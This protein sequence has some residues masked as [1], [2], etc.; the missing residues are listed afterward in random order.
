MYSVSDRRDLSK[1]VFYSILIV[2]ALGASFAVGLYSGAKRTGLFVLA[3]SARTTI[4]SA[5]TTLIGQATTIAGTRP[6]GF[7]Q[8]S[9]S[10]RGGVTINDALGNQGDLILLSGF[11]GDTSELRLIRRSGSVV[12]RWPVSYY[13]LFK[14][15]GQFDDNAVPATDWN[16]DTHGALALPDGSVV[17]NFEYGGLVKLDRCGR[18]LWTVRRRTHHSVEAAEGGG[19]WVPARRLVREGPSPYRPFPTPFQEDTILKVTDDGTIAFEKSVP[20]IMY[21]NGMEPI[22]TATGTSFEAGMPWDEEILHL[23]KIEELTGDLAGD[24]PLFAK[25]DLL[26]SIRDFNML[27]VV[28]AGATKVKWWKVGPWVRQHDPEF[29]PGGGI[30]MFNNNIYDTAFEGHEFVTPLSAPRVSTITRIDPAT[31]SYRTLYGGTSDQELLSIIR[32]KVDQTAGGGL[33]IT[34]FEGGRVLETDAGGR[35][36]WE[37]IN[38]YSESEVAEITEGRLYPEGYFAVADWSCAAGGE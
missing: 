25:G 19:Y 16:V 14:N 5:F 22:L 11:F 3:D 12:A 24:F 31:N 32:G 9:R 34:E 4:T 23:N 38:R 33:F 29:V 8:A 37:Y 17:F 7:L 28:D 2:A 30:I 21:E 1:I 20:A 15:P 10:S 6:A 18:T 13:R 26:L 27:L 35:V 36:V